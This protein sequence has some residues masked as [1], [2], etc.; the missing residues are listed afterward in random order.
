ME[1]NNNVETGHS[2]N[3]AAVADQPVKT[4]AIILGVGVASVVVLKLA[5]ALINK[6]H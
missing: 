5:T 2:L 3:M 6:I 1:Q 4:T